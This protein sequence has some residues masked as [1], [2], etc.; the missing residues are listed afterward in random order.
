VIPVTKNTVFAFSVIQTW[1]TVHDDYIDFT[2]LGR[3]GDAGWLYR[4]ERG[5]GIS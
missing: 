5:R 3:L 4:K 1:I 2:K